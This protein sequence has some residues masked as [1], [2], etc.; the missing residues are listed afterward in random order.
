ML[1]SFSRRCSR[2]PRQGTP[3]FP[4]LRGPKIAPMWVRMFA[5]PG[6]A[7]IGQLQQVPVA[8]DVQVKKV[9]EFLGVTD[10][11]PM[12]PDEARREIQV[13]WAADVQAEGATGPQS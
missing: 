4:L 8:V 9:T 10:T 3:H 12:T 13:A 6:L 11:G 5:Y 7:A 2:K 1:P